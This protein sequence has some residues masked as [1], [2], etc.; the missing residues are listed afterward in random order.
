MEHGRDYPQSKGAVEGNTED[1]AEEGKED[2]ESE[3]MEEL[4]GELADANQKQAAVSAKASAASSAQEAGEMEP[5]RPPPAQD[6]HVEVEAVDQVSL[7][8]TDL[9]DAKDGSTEEEEP[10]EAAAP[11]PAEEEEEEGAEVQDSAPFKHAIQTYE[12][13]WHDR[14]TGWKGQTHSAAVDFCSS[15]RL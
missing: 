12:P 2:W 13:Q 4:I 7:S 1:N 10:E 9:Q 8:T 15:Q 3:V 6:A 11:A 5:V 14:S